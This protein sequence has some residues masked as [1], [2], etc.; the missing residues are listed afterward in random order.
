M[1]RSSSRG[2][3][4]GR[5][6]PLLVPP[7]S[8]KSLP[9]IKPGSVPQPKPGSAGTGKAGASAVNG[10][11]SSMMIRQGGPV[12]IPQ[13]IRTHTHELRNLKD[14]VQRFL[15]R[16]ASSNRSSSTDLQD[17]IA[18]L[19]TYSSFYFDLVRQ[20]TV[21]SVEL[22][23]VQALLWNDFVSLFQRLFTLHERTQTMVDTE[24]EKARAAAQNEA[25]KDRTELRQLK[26]EL[27]EKLKLQDD[28]IRRKDRTIQMHV[29][30]Q[31]HLEQ[32]NLHLRELLHA[33]EFEESSKRRDKGL[34]K[35]VDKLDN[36]IE[37]VES[38]TRNQHNVVMDMKR[39][40]DQVKF[41]QDL[42]A[43]KECIDIATQYDDNSYFVEN[44]LGSL[45]E[46]GDKEKE[47]A[48]EESH[49]HSVEA[50][51]DEEVG[52]RKKR[53]GKEAKEKEKEKSWSEIWATLRPRPDALCWTKK[54]I[55]KFVAQIYFD[56]IIADEIDDRDNKKRANLPDFCYESVLNKYGLKTLAKKNMMYVIASVHRWMGESPRIKMFAQFVG[57]PS[58]GPLR[59][60][61]V[62]N[63]YLY[64]V[65]Y[66]HGNQKHHADEVGLGLNVLAT[67]SNLSLIDLK[68]AE[69]AASWL[70]TEC[71]QSARGV[72][73]ELS[74]EFR[75]VLT[76]GKQNQRCI[77]FDQWAELLVT[78]W[79]EELVKSKHTLESMFIS[80][81]VDN[82]GILTY[83]E[84]SAL[85]WS[86]KPE[87]SGREMTSLYQQAQSNSVTDSLTPEDFVKVASDHGLLSHMMRNKEFTTLARGDDFVYLETVWEEAK[88]RI[89]SDLLLLKASPCDEELHQQLCSRQ[90][91]FINLLLERDNLAASWL[92]YR[93]LESGIRR[94]ILRF[95]DDNAGEES[96]D[97]LE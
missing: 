52:E 55:E 34:G 46:D 37:D 86:I 76:Q 49:L 82:D 93:T 10:K 24:T 61:D 85:V 23:R 72:L 16:N 27:E 12:Y 45:P 30:H 31:N 9:Q 70:H 57:A 1:S 63:F 50:D 18:D 20:A 4:R 28:T 39:L 40:V 53:R 69:Q 94:A 80:A 74:T 51:E 91:K 54:S 15:K 29:M 97:F 60:L 35:M 88:D 8:K 64:A 78:K 7:K 32:E 21:H 90:A 89:E 48:E 33:E 62:L 6:T 96:D 84:F 44:G 13:D 79:E 36:L 75:T 87:T 11:L 66:T 41:S 22:G 5:D 38:E 73:Q 47:K 67:E 95:V 26:L 17:I 19:E 83:D 59:D 77:Q 43:A 14:W 92:C 68:H 25:L 65:K 56:K 58:A 2:E 71:F 3:S 81:D 42:G